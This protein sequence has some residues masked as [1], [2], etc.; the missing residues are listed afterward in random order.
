MS[1]DAQLLLKALKVPFPA[2][3]LSFRVTSLLSFEVF[4]IAHIS[5]RGF[6]HQ[7]SALLFACNYIRDF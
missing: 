7:N 5:L 4:I 1:L 3:D 2:V 6:V